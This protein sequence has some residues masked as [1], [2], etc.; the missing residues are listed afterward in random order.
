MCERV[1]KKRT[2]V[3]AEKMGEKEEESCTRDIRNCSALFSTFK[4]FGKNCA[5]GCFL[6]PELLEVGWRWGGGISFT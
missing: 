1:S 2:G 5:I 3:I 4:Y 6:E